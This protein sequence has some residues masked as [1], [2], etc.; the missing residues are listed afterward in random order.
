L[1]TKSKKAGTKKGR[2]KVGKLKLNKETVKDLTGGEGKRIKGGLVVA[3][4]NYLCVPLPET[5]K[6]IKITIWGNTCATCSPQPGCPAG[7]R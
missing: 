5:L 6:C 1:V 2:V 4:V 7:L 3:T